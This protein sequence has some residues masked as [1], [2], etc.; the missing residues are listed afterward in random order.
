M[1]GRVQLRRILQETTF[2][3]WLYYLL[4]EDIFE[5]TLFELRRIIIKIK[6]IYTT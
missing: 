4:I 2:K 6:N 5:G 3:H 1:Y